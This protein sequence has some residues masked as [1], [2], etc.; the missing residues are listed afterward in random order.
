MR[1]SDVEGLLLPMYEFHGDTED[2]ISSVSV[3]CPPP[4][5]P[6][7]TEIQLTSDE[8]APPAPASAP[9]PASPTTAATRTE[10]VVG[11]NKSTPDEVALDE[12]ILVFLGE[13]PSKE[14]KYGPKIQNEIA[15]RWEHAATSGVTKD[16]RK[17]FLEKYLTPENC[18]LA[19]PPALNLEV[20]AALSDTLQ[21]KDTAIQHKQKQISA[22]VS[23]IGL[24]VQRTLSSNHKDPELLKLL[25]DA[26][27]IICDLQHTESVLRRSY[28]CSC[29]KKDVKEH[30]N[31]TQ[32]DK[33]LFGD[34][35]ADTLRT[36]KSITKSGSEIRASTSGSR[37]VQKNKP[38]NR[39]LNSRGP[40]TMSRPSSAGRRA[41]EIA[42]AFA[43]AF[44][45]QVP[46]PYPL[47]P[48]R[49]APPP[50]PPLPAPRSQLR[51]RAPRR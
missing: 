14:K 23:C 21:K 31:D 12:E 51:P 50:P 26:G 43:P 6:D 42:P 1:I 44:M 22:A 20:K 9:A 41:E 2:R 37:P 13:A 11:E 15:N 38:S 36:A 8:H 34:K 28:I 32:I 45:P 25:I 10:P 19:D 5:V 7:E 3:E 48:R 29:I 16:V 4:P 47:P 46:A 18:K 30:L 33:Y 49:R 40:A 24:A 35:L 27:R 39:P 17:D